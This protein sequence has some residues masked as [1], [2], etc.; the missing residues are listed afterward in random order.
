MSEELIMTLCRLVS[1]AAAE[2]AVSECD[3]Y[4]ADIRINSLRLFA[5]YLII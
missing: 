2:K 5:M 1:E 4:T 3:V